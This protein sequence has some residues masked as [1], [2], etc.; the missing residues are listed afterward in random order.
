MHWCEKH[1]KKKKITQRNEK[2]AGGR[3]GS[4]GMIKTFSKQRNIKW[5]QSAWPRNMNTA[6]VQ[7]ARVQRQFH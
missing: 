5:L 3:G 2:E 6:R 4:S 7:V 1:E